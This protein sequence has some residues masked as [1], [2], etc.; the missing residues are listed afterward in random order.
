MKNN[1]IGRR[2][3]YLRKESNLTLRQLGE[4]LG[5]KGNTAD[6]R[7][8]QYESGN[9]VPKGKLLKKMADA[10]DV[11]PN[12]IIPPD[13]DTIEG[14]MHTLFMLDDIY[15][16]T[17][18]MNLRDNCIILHLNNQLEDKALQNEVLQAS[19]I[20]IMATILKD[21]CLL[22][23]NDYQRWKHNYPNI[24]LFELVFGRKI[25]LETVLRTYQAFLD[26]Q[27]NTS[28]D[29]NQTDALYTFGH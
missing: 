8:S 13:Y 26:D 29:D 7:M 10:L 5:F 1:N 4:M 17:P 23:Y 14:L 3:H 11:S 28:H 22:T 21:Y 24:N 27:D 2:I 18:E 19:S 15:E 16:F 9:R 6:V 25:D 20:W 12:T